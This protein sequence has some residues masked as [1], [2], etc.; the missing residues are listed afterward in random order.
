[1]IKKALLK[2]LFERLLKYLLVNCLKLTGW[3]LYLGLKVADILWVKVVSPFVDAKIR[4]YQMQQRAYRKQTQLV[5]IKSVTNK[6]NFGEHLKKM[7]ATQ[8]M[9]VK[10]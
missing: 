10:S 4:E 9:D 1:M 5:H 6:H 8:R 2:S 7:W 3:S